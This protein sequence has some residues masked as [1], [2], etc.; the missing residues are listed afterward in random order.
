MF[1]DDRQEY[2]GTSECRLS[3]EP[4][5]QPLISRERSGSVD[6]V[7]PCPI[8]SR[9]SRIQESFLCS[10]DTH[11]LVFSEGHFILV[12]ILNLEQTIHPLD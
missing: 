11:G 5:E 6:V 1:V 10:N 8:C 4:C 3:S 12:Y 7:K 2:I 9:V